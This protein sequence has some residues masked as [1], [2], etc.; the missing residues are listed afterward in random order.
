[1]EIASRLESLGGLPLVRDRGNNGRPGIR[2]ELD[3]L[4]REANARW[5]VE[6]LCILWKSWL[7]T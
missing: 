2:V 3:H 6:K 5:L 1:M 4:D 7:N